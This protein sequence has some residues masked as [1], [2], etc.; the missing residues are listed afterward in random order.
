MFHLFLLKPKSAF[1]KFI[2]QKEW[3]FIHA[4]SGAQAEK[5][6]QISLQITPPFS[7]PKYAN[8]PAH[9]SRAVMKPISL[10]K[11]PLSG[12][13]LGKQFKPCDVWFCVSA[14]I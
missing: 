13:S 10:S 6:Q 4:T 14:A 1:Q 8:Q 11:S 12:P 3:E 2:K 7:F 9:N 5:M